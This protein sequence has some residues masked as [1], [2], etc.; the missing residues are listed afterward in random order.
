M[1]CARLDMTVDGVRNAVDEIEVQR[2]PSGD[3]N[4][5]GNAFTRRASR[6]RRES[7]AQRDAA[8]PQAGR[9]R[10]AQ[11]VGDPVRPR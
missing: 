6:L 10:G 3:D 7:E 2:V 1:F 11:P 9:L 8:N 5:W 4:P